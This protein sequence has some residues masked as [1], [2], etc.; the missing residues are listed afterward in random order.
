[1]KICIFGKI[2]RYMSKNLILGKSMILAI[3]GGISSRKNTVSYALKENYSKRFN[4]TIE[5]ISM[6]NYYKNAKNEN[7]DNYDHP[8]A[9]DMDLLYI[10]LNNYLSTG[11]I[12]KRSYDFTSKEN[13][14]LQTQLDV[15][16]L[17]LE[18]LYPFYDEKIRDICGI[19]LYLDVD[20]DIRYS[21][22]IKRD[23]K[24]RSITRKENQIMIDTFV[25]K[26]YTK[27]VTEQK[28]MADKVF[29]SYEEILSLL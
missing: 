28:S 6:D 25:K 14:I 29:K 24:E 4:I 2:L 16:L 8:Q 5:V 3:A 11:S 17:I 20:E 7:F 22:R 13:S 23:L 1:M 27:Y 10:D 12:V 15:K 18:G 21:R 9:F 19:K 26:M